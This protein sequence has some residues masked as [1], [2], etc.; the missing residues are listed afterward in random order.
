MEAIDLR[1]VIRDVPDTA[2]VMTEEPFGPIAP[3]VPFKS[4]DEVVERANSI[5]NKGTPAARS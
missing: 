4:F 1:H 5:A 3:I 2:R